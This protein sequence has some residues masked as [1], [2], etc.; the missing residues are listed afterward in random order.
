MYRL[1]IHLTC[2]VFQEVL[3]DTILGGKVEILFRNVKFRSK[4]ERTP[5]F[6]QL[7]MST[8]NK[9]LM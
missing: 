8:F 6:Y 9:G 5:L 7:I 1:E 4:A 2:K 3:S